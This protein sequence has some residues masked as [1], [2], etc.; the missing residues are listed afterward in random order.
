MELGGCEYE[1]NVKEVEVEGKKGN[2][3]EEEEEEE[4]K[5]KEKRKG[6]TKGNASKRKV[7]GNQWNDAVMYFG[8]REKKFE[9]GK[10]TMKT[11][12]Q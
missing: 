5:K 1:R 10:S 4:E 12:G 8:L 11:E 3:R 2:A 9:R 6:K 7:T